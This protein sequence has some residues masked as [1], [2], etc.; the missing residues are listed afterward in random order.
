MK[1]LMLLFTLLLFF[2]TLSAQLYHNAY[3]DN[4]NPAIVFLHGGP[5][6][7]CFTF[8]ASTAQALAD[9]GYYVVVFD[10]RGCGR[11]STP[12]DSKFTFEE[13]VADVDMILKVNGVK[14]ATLIGHSWGGA[15]G[16]MF[17]EKH[18]D[19]V[20]QLVLVG[21]PMDYPHTFETIITH[22]REAYKEQGNETQSR[23]LDMLETM[24]KTSL[25][26]AN[27]CFM[28][29]MAAGLYRTDNPAPEAAEIKA[30]L[31]ASPDIAQASKM[32]PEP[33]QKLYNNEQYTNLNLY[34]RLAKVS[35]TIPVYGIFGED[36]GLF[37]KE[38]LDEIAKA[39]GKD[40]LSVVFGAS[41][42]V[43]I[44]QQKEFIM[45]LNKFIGK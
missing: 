23:Y 2:N 14:K 31:K 25:Q 36:D 13:A 42:A 30:R 18:P 26:Y 8:E 35:K 28:Q 41:H 20:K 24:D 32:T 5:G 39:I 38:Q 7:N 4:K 10:Q 43:F 34:E 15:L 11:S 17:A 19:K 16:V 21:A 6:Y 40:R 3:G 45:F 33:V 1:N 27:Y 37:D 22:C 44:D 29:A 9:E 12:D